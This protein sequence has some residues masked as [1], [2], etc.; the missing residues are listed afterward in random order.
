M[1]KM[2]GNSGQLSLGKKFAGRYFKVEPQPNGA[3]LLRP[4]T[5]I[6][7]TEAWAHEPTMLGQLQRADEWAKGTKP[8][9]TKLDS[10]AAK[11]AKR[12]GKRA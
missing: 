3:L 10:L 2:V 1:L 4:M 12:R 8:A 11:A 7:T 5:L 6:P 9:E